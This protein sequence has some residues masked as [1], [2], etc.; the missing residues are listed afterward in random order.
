MGKIECYTVDGLLLPPSAYT[1]D[2]VALV[3]NMGVYGTGNTLP[4]S[5]TIT[6]AA[7]TQ[8]SK[9]VIR[10]RQDC[11]WQRL[12]GTLLEIKNGSNVLKSVRL[13]DADN[14]VITL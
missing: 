14:Q 11:C 7:P 3:T 13:T 8:L 12:N 6:L 9:V 2:N 5:M 1:G 4:T 10:T